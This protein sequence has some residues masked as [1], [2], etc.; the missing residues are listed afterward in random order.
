MSF[1]ES[2]Q[3]LYKSMESDLDSHLEFCKFSVFIDNETLEH[4]INRYAEKEEPSAV[5]CVAKA[6]AN[7][8]AGILDALAGSSVDTFL[9]TSQL[10]YLQNHAFHFSEI[11]SIKYQTETKTGFFGGTKTKN[12]LVVSKKSGQSEKFNGCMAEEPIA[13]FLDAIAKKYAENPPAEPP[14]Q[15]FPR[16][17]LIID[18]L[19]AVDFP[20]FKLTPNLDDCKI[21][22]IL[23]KLG[24]FELK[25]S[26]AASYRKELFFSNDN[27]YYSENGEFK[28]IP[29]NQL[30][31]ATYSEIDRKDSNG[32]IIT[33]KTLSLRAKDGNVIFKSESS[34]AKTEVADFFNKIISD[35]TGTEVKTESHIQ[36]MER[37]E[38]TSNNSGDMKS[39]L[40]LI[41]KGLLDFS[42]EVLIGSTVS[43]AYHLIV[44]SGNKKNFSTLLTEW[45]D[46]FKKSAFFE[47]AKPSVS[48]N[49][50]PEYFGQG[51]KKLLAS[52]GRENIFYYFDTKQ[53]YFL[54]KPAENKEYLFSFSLLD[55][56]AYKGRFHGYGALDGA[57]HRGSLAGY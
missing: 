54:Y 22:S 12:Y 35:A 13:L 29:Y 25:A 19:S 16:S 31:V 24:M 17:K 9:F 34:I 32:E 1:L 40:G 49:T 21:N 42:A 36:K 15:D 52:N 41:G 30:D 47:N 26:F 44:A 38:P 46:I 5:L 18:S 37:E 43:N 7:G 4:N 23:I 8:N 28:K 14:A 6:K 10:L 45:N 33:T 57:G 53:Y 2:V 11:H 3:E 55:Y 51:D 20:N 39:T 48:F 27:L 50:L 56:S